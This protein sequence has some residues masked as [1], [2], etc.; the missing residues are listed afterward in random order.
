MSFS[1]GCPLQPWVLRQIVLLAPSSASAEL[2][3]PALV[4]SKHSLPT[5][6]W[7]AGRR[8]G[9]PRQ[10]CARADGW[11]SGGKPWEE[12]GALH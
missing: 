11:V 12:A 8:I 10:R 3:L 9:E 1:S 6:L 5:P 7:R 2:F 4:Y